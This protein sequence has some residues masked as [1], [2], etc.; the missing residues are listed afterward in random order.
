[1]RRG[2]LSWLS[3][4]QD[5]ICPSAFED[6]TGHTQARL[7]VPCNREALKCMHEARF[8]FHG[9]HDRHTRS[10]SARKLP[11]VRLDLHGTAGCS[12]F[13]KGPEASPEESGLD[14]GSTRRRRDELQFSIYNQVVRKVASFEHVDHFAFQWSPRDQPERSNC[15]T[16]AAGWDSHTI[17]HHRSRPSSQM[18]TYLC[19]CL[20]LHASHHMDADLVVSS[21]ISG[22]K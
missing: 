10:K 21:S 2:F 11:S 1:M 16:F 7:V 9:R 17:W 22:R 14:A 3:C 6:H 5:L 8:W 15:D 19:R 12:A 20:L 13:R 4:N 18:E